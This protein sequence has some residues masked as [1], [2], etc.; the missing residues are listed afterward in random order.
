MKIDIATPMYGGQC[1]GEYHEAVM[2]FYFAAASRGHLVRSR[3]TFNESLIQRARNV[4]ASEFLMD[5]QNPDYLLFIDSDIDFDANKMLDMIEEG[6]DVIGAI[7]P[8]KHIDFV[9]MHQLSTLNKSYDN[10]ELLGSLYNINVKDQDAV[11]DDLINNVSFEVDRIGTGVMAIKRSVLEEMSKKVEEYIDDNNQMFRV[12]RWNFFPVTIE[13]DERWGG[14]RMMSED[15]NFCNIWRSMGG[16]VYA[17]NGVV[18]GHNGYYK[19]KG[20]LGL[21]MKII[22]SA[23]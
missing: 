20:D 8:I 4:L 11:S 16:K 18:R 2:N 1:F 5:D 12:K 6:K 13:H 3:F 21:Q 22:N 17:K 10:I 14:N 15:Y 7:T 9:K 23:H 19:Y